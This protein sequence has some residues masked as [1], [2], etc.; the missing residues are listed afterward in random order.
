MPSL[1]RALLDTGMDLARELPA[2][3]WWTTSGETLPLDLYRKFRRAMPDAILLNLYGSSEVSADVTAWDSRSGEPQETVPI[4]RPISNCRIYILDSKAQPVPI[5]VP[6]E[7]YVGGAGLARGY[8]GHPEWTAERFVPD[9]FSRVPGE[10]LFRTGDRG[11][12]REDGQI[13]FLG[14]TDFQIKL[15]GRRIEPGEI[16]AALGEHAAVAEAVVTAREGAPGGP[17]LAA[18]VLTRPGQT[19]TAAGMREFLASRLPEFMIPSA[20]VFLDAFPRTASGKLDRARLPEPRD[21]RDETI[22]W[23]PPR[24]TVEEKVAR[25]WREVLGMERVGIRDNFFENGGH[26]LLAVTLAAKLEKEFGR[27]VG[28][29]TIFRAPTIAELAGVV[30]ERRRSR[31][32]T[33]SLVALQPNGSRP[34]FYCVHAVPGIIQYHLLA[35]SVGRDQPF[36]AL[37]SQGLEGASRPYETIEEMAAHYVAEIRERQPRGPYYLGG[38]SFGG[39]VAFE[40]ARQLRTLGEETAF[41]AF[42]DTLNIPTIPR[43]TALEHARERARVHVAFLR[44]AGLKEKLSYLHG[45]AETARSLAVRGVF[46]LYERLIRP[47]R[48]ALFDPHQRARRRVLAT[49]FRAAARYVPG[50]Y[51][52]RV[53]I[54]RATD[55]PDGFRDRLQPYP[56]LGWEELCTGVE[57]IEVP[58]GHSSLMEEEANVRALGRVLDER[59]RAAQCLCATPPVQ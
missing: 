44:A 3:R 35:R 30:R 25:V 2:L 8:R 41:L 38:Y 29:A 16:E 46:A 21:F 36:Y 54:F 13:E 7:I 45:R 17:A 22:P 4:G 24:D 48:E 23:E 20:F 19:A 43:P 47:V 1:L 31:S 59:L 28:L 11:R 39:K 51:D 32:R 49:N 40:M 50:H 18:Y 56:L 26:S 33:P 10:R 15:R 57:L 27:P 55:R 9:P 34:P 5:G 6:G 12:Y 52:G 58:G 37:Q 14:R 42:F 53:T